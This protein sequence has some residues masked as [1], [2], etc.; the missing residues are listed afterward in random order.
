MLFFFSEWLL[1]ENE[2]AYFE[3]MSKE[4]LAKTLERFYNGVTPKETGDDNWTSMKSI[5][6]ALQRHLSNP[7]YSQTYNI[8]THLAFRQANLAYKEYVGKCLQKPGRE[9]KKQWIRRQDVD[10]LYEEV[11]TET[12]LGLQRRMFFEIYLNFGRRNRKMLM[13]L[14]KDDLD[15]HKEE[16]GH[17]VVRLVRSEHAG[18]KCM[19]ALPG[20]PKNCP[21]ENLKKYIEHLDPES[22]WFFQRPRTSHHPLDRVWY[23][24]KVVGTNSRLDMMPTMSRECRLSRRY[25]NTAV[26][27]KNTV[28]IMNTIRRPL[29]NIEVRQ[30]FSY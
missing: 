4:K 11:F 7:P 30:K 13:Q 5:R 28:K 19:P 3:G 8:I 27:N 2:N 10:K 16:N 9:V 17:E 14:K 29:R 15:V 1:S 18:E 23:L 22:P 25:S 21:V 20:D 24:P 6:A 26:W 12:P